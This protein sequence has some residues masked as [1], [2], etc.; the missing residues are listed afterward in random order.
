MKTIIKN[1]CLADTNLKAWASNGG[2]FP[3]NPS[4]VNP[5]SIDLRLG[6]Q[7]RLPRWYW[8]FPFRRLAN[9][10]NLPRWS[11]P[12]SFEKY[13]LMP[14]EFVLCSSLE[15]TRIPDD[16]LAILLSKSST[17]RRGI[18]HLHAGLG[19]P[20]FGDNEI[21]GAQ[22]TWELTNVAPWPNLL[23]AGKALMQLVLVTTT[24]VPKSTYKHTGRYNEQWGPTP[25]KSKRS[26]R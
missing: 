3:Y 21:G 8:V 2:V 7:I 5:A 9:R 15:A 22:W 19:D 25:Q 10:L 26:R 23:E 13:L 12:I 24:D 4:L 1:G 6:N 18:E 11:E 17:G 14:G 20:G 16:T